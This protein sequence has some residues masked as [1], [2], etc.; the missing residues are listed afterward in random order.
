MLPSPLCH[1]CVLGMLLLLQ[2]AHGL[3]CR[4]RGGLPHRLLMD[5]RPRSYR[6][7]G[8]GRR[9]D[10]GLLQQEEEKGPLVGTGALN[11]N[12]EQIR[13]ESVRAIQGEAGI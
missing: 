7:A 8:G 11:S 3:I 1:A 12:S 4:G 5:P 13:S 6:S 10:L 2:R 9:D